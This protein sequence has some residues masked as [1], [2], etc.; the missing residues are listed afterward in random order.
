[1]WWSW[2]NAA[3]TVTSLNLLRILS[4]Q[5]FYRQVV[6]HCSN[7][8]IK[9][10]NQNYIMLGRNFQYCADQRGW[11]FFWF[12][13]SVLCN[14]DLFYLPTFAILGLTLQISVLTHSLLSTFQQLLRGSGKLMLLDKL[15]VRLRETGHR[16]LIFSQMVRMLDIL[17]QYLQYRRFPFQRLDGSI[18]GELRRQALDHFN[19][20][21]SQ[22]REC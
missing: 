3:T 17:A 16:V 18:K 22:V 20:E 10:C 8:I 5:R 4:Q 19:A 12:S 15:L 6:I 13:V 14:L 2:R 21:G 1:M 9:F 7:V 11:A